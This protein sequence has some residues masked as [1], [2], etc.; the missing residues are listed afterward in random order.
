MYC[1]YQFSLDFEST[2]LKSLNICCVVKQSK[3]SE[4]ARV[5]TS[6]Y[7]KIKLVLAY[8]IDLSCLDKSKI[9]S[10]VPQRVE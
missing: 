6:I 2:I 8:H 9:H 1:C 10:Y 5:S 4:F 7:I 3:T